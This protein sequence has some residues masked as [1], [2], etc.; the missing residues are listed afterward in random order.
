VQVVSD[1]RGEEVVVNDPRV[2]A[3]ANILVDYSVS[4]RPGQLV[5][6]RAKPEGE[7]LLLALYAAVLERGGHP[8]VD[9]QH[10]GTEE[11][12]FAL[13]EEHQLDYVAPFE[14]PMI[15][16]FEASIHVWTDA[17]TKRLTG[18]DPA[19]QAR[20]DRATG[21]L[22]NRFLERVGSGELRWVGT[23]HPTQASAQNAEMSLGEF[24]RFVYDACLVHEPD[25]I[26][27]WKEV[28][29]SQ[30]RLVDWLA[31]KREIH[32][33]GKDVDLR[34]SVAGRPWENCDGHE[35]FPDGEIFT[36]PLE[37]SV[38]G[39]IRFSFPACYNGREV[40]NVLLRFE[41]GKV[42]HVEAAKNLRFL[43]E[44][45]EVD[46]GARYVG[47]FAFGT[48][49]GIT[50]FTKETLFDEKIG[51]TIHLAL[52]KGYPE[53]GSENDSAIHWDMVCDLREEGRVLVDGETF[54]EKGRFTV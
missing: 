10:E 2:L 36:S 41:K 35:N 16:A 6:L 33:Q 17:N 53:T 11:L 51:G 45:L 49:A 21:P 30:Q 7:P 52:G 23:V 47:E 31:D 13:A 22:F 1:T 8:W 54:L 20:R 37:D 32:V 46:A 39:E 4:V 42:V 9:L 28:S 5:R 24:E 19:K 29:A 12:F 40:E 14:L 26:A 15:D 25:P 48:N 50:R 34:L 38:E 43:E 18:A 27:A 44:M 3:V